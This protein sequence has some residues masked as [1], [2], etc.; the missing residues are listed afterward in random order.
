MTHNFIARS[1][2]TYTPGEYDLGI[3]DPT[4]VK[5]EPSFDYG[6]IA[7][8]D[9]YYKFAI[10]FTR[11]DNLYREVGEHRSNPFENRVRYN[12]LADLSSG[13]GPRSS[14]RDLLPSTE[15]LQE[16]E[17]PLYQGPLN[18]EGLREKLYGAAKKRLSKYENVTNFVE[19]PLRSDLIRYA[20]NNNPRLR[21]QIQVSPFD[22]GYTYIQ[23]HTAQN[24]S[25]NDKLMKSMM[26]E[27]DI[28]SN[29]EYKNRD[30]YK[31]ENYYVKDNKSDIQIPT[32]DSMDLGMKQHKHKYEN[33]RAVH[34][35]DSQRVEHMQSKQRDYTQNIKRTPKTHNIQK[36]RN[37]GN[38]DLGNYEHMEN[39]VGRVKPDT[40]KMKNSLV[41]ENNIS[42]REHINPSKQPNRNPYV[43]PNK[44]YNLEQ[45]GFETFELDQ[46]RA[47]MPVN[48]M[49]MRHTSNNENININPDKNSM[50]FHD[51]K[52]SNRMVRINNTN[53]LETKDESIIINSVLKHG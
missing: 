1:T 27:T 14:V 28:A 35:P 11:S 18:F 17:A 3:Y 29:L 32:D 21:G 15:L 30:Y 42:G 39:Q 41:L 2:G 45:E 40:V 24:T 33:N 49:P 8:P 53:T 52:K 37:D 23:N 16:V 34:N 46:G 44:S 19:P 9:A 12:L 51:H 43:R 31:K 7:D 50:K 38:I 4:F 22:N 25:F 6:N 48:K 10:E 13:D 26:I 47:K 5:P 36:K 20:W